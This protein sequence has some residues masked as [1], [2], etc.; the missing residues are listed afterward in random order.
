D[1][2]AKKYRILLTSP[3]MLHKNSAFHEDLNAIMPS[4]DKLVIDE[5]H[6]ID[7]WGADF[8]PDYAILGDLRSFFP[9]S[10]H[11]VRL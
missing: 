5:A 9:K 7:Q 8:R 11:R 3:E 4:I 6:C 10:W 2:R 1:I